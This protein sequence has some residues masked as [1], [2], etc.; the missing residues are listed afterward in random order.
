[1]QTGQRVG[2]D[3]GVGVEQQHVVGG[4]PE[5]RHRHVDGGSEPDVGAGVEV[6][7]AGRARQAAVSE[8][9][10]LST[11]TIGSCPARAASAPARVSDDPKATMT[12]STG[13]SLP[14]TARAPPAG[15]PVGR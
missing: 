2:R 7:R 9:D 6:L 5:V 1:M 11:T 8:D 13:A 12:T 3:A 14:L 4:R 15:G 10:E